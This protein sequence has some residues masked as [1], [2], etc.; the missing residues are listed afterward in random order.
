MNPDPGAQT[1]QQVVPGWRGRVPRAQV[2]QEWACGVTLGVSIFLAGHLWPRDSAS[3][4]L[5][6]PGMA[7]GLRGGERGS[8]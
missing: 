7:V 1:A 2:C 8:T 3:I 6:V 5:P 4:S